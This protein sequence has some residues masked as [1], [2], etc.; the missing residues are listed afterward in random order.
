MTTKLSRLLMLV[1]ICGILIFRVAAPVLA[2]TITVNTTSDENNTGSFCSLRE[3]I[4]AADTDSAYGGC[5]AGSGADIITLP[6]GTYQ[7]TLGAAAGSNALVVDSEITLNGAGA[8][9]TFIQGGAAA[10][11]VAFGMMEVENTGNLTLSGVTV[12]Y[13]GILTP[14]PQP[15]LGGGMLVEAG[16]ALTLTGGAVISHN[17][18]LAGAGIAAEAAT[19]TI[20]NNA[21]IESNTA[22]AGGGGLAQF[23]G[24]LDMDNAFVVGNSVATN[25]G[26]GGAGIAY[27]GASGTVTIDNSIVSFNISA[28]LGGGVSIGAT[29]TSVTIT[30]SQIEFNEATNGSAVY[31]QGDTNTS[32]SITDSCIV[33]NNDTAVV[34]PGSLATVADGNWWGSQYGAY[35][36][37]P[38][39][40]GDSI[41][42]N[43]TVNNFASEAPFS[44]GMCTPPSSMGTAVRA[45]RVC[46]PGV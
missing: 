26:G 6:A 10:N 38:D 14:A 5:S 16:G 1:F 36:L 32:S 15:S 8:D 35:P 18:A 9:V 23:G 44:C 46:T 7:M 28:G 45:S 27:G 22:F 4:Q 19:I 24:T 34:D 13:G 21:R 41:S 17:R 25:V 11:T 39:S 40:F 29:D 20:E 31:L 3:A 2:A 33:G 43:V 12:R 37:D 30:N 42:T